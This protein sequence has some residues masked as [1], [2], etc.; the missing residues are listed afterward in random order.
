MSSFKIFTNSAEVMPTF[1]LF[2][3]NVFNQITTHTIYYILSNIS[4][5]TLFGHYRALHYIVNKVKSAINII[6]S[7]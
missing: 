2:I 1:T 3:L 6:C 4:A 7:F 5:W